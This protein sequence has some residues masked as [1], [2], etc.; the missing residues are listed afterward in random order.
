MTFIDASSL[1][2]GKKTTISFK[3]PPTSTSPKTIKMIISLKPITVGQSHVKVSYDYD[4]NLLGSDGYTKNI[5]INPV[6]IEK[7][8]LTVNELGFLSW[9]NVK[10]ADYYMIYESGGEVITDL[11]GEDIVVYSEGYAVGDTIIFNLGQYVEGLHLIYIRAYSN[12]SSITPSS[13][14]EIVAHNW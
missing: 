1:K 10:N 8:E 4:Y 9:N 7:P 3:V 14:S 2:E 12:N 5:T 11:Y 6:Q 13:Y